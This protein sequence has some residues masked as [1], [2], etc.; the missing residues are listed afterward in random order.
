MVRLITWSH[1]Q[2]SEYRQLRLFEHT[3]LV[4]AYN[5]EMKARKRANKKR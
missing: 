2:P 5:L 1:M 4:K 3:A